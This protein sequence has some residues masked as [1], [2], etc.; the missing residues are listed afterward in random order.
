MVRAGQGQGWVGEI[1]VRLWFVFACARAWKGHVLACPGW[2]VIADL[3]DIP[4]F[5]VQD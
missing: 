3:F 4:L 5:V 1:P 2:D